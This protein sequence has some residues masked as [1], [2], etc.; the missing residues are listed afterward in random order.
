M[1]G[2]RT[3]R[4]ACRPGGFV[5]T[6]N[7]I[8]VTQNEGKP[9]RRSR[10][11]GALRARRALKA[12]HT[13]LRTP[14]QVLVDGLTRFASSAVFLAIHFVWFTIWILWN[15]GAFGTRPFDPFPF[16]LLTLVVSLEAIFLSIFILMS[17]SREAEIAELRE[18]VT[19]QVDLRIEEE[20]TKTL[21]LVAGLYPRLGFE[22]GNDDELREMLRPLDEKRIEE[23]M[24]QQILLARTESN[25]KADAG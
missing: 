16:G 15:T 6:L 24:R 2:E 25:G 12:E 13:R 8:A 18:E 21:Q 1:L 20:V 14:A 5:S 17:Q 3:A 11:A 4:V 23:E 7:P 22:M 10:A 19:L 9:D